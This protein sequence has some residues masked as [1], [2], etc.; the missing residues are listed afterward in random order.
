VGFELLS[1][2]AMAFDNLLLTRNHSLVQQ[3]SVEWQQRFDAE[4]HERVRRVEREE[5]ELL[6]D[7]SSYTNAELL[8]VVLAELHHIWHTQPAL[9]VVPSLY[10]FM[11]TCMLW[12]GVKVARESWRS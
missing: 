4:L 12:L 3:L 11:I 2:E 1:W 10:A 6:P 5:N 8:R 9:L 7:F